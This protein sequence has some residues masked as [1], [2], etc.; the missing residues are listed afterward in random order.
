MSI[1]TP[2]TFAQDFGHGDQA[3]A[4]LAQA[5]HHQA[6]HQRGRQ[7]QFLEGFHEFPNEEP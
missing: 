6:A 5:Q 2:G 1:R 4:L 7:E 3:Q